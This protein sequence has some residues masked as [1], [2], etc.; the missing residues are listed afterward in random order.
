[1][2]SYSRI[3]KGSGGF[4]ET[5]NISRTVLNE[6][7]PS[8]ELSLSAFDIVIL[9]MPNGNTNRTEAKIEFTPTDTEPGNYTINLTTFD[10]DNSTTTLFFNIS[11]F[12]NGPPE[13]NETL[14]EPLV[15]LEYENNNTYL[16]FSLNVSDPDGSD[17]L[18]FT[19]TNDSSFPDFIN[20]FKS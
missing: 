3:T 20:G 15:I 5:L 16:N 18:T 9:S 19:F 1:L 4:N 13:W 8:Q 11:I 17:T 10:V 14:T 6:S 7:N 12:S 2:F